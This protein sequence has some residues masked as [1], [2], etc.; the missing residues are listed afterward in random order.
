MHWVD[1]FLSGWFIAALRTE[2]NLPSFAR[3]WI[4]MLEFAWSKE[5]W[6]K[7]K[8]R[9]HVRQVELQLHLLGFSHGEFLLHDEKYLPIVTP[10]KPQF[11]RWIERLL[12]NPEATS[13]YAHFLALPSA[14]N[15][16]RDGVKR[17][18]E[19]TPKF[20]EGHW[21]DFYHLDRN[22]LRLLEHD[23]KANSAV[24]K[25]NEEVRLQFTTLLKTLSDRPVPGA[26]ELRDRIAR[27]G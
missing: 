20:N 18:S 14:A 7:S 16:L 19:A 13:R 17:L 8:V 23:W 27:S 9:H 5:N 1:S 24:I 25:N 6:W 21:S 10:M 15:H 22:L 3:Q 12:P 4:A 26:L 2:L 11:D